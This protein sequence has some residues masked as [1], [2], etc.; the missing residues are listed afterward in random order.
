MERYKRRGIFFAVLATL[1][2]CFIFHNSLQGSEI[3]NGRSGLVAA[4]L[5]GL[6]DPAD[7]FEEESFHKFI[8]KAAH[9]IEFAGLGLCLGG[10]AADLGRWQNRVYRSFPVLLA[11]LTAVC[12]EFIQQFT[13]RTSAVKD[14]VLDFSGALSGMLLIGAIFGICQKKRVRR[15]RM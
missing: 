4:F 13:G 11:L 6:L 5:K 8:R 7:R 2:V 14:V 10:M 15:R 12:D 3:S 9:F 1:I